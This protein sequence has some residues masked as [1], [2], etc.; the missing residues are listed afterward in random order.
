MAEL[1]GLKERA[2]AS[3][4]FTLPPIDK[5]IEFSV[6]TGERDTIPFGVIAAFEG[7]SFLFGS[8]YPLSKLQKWGDGFWCWDCCLEFKIPFMVHVV[9]YD[10]NVEASKW[11][12]G[13][14]FPDPVERKGDP[15]QT[16]TW[17]LE[18]SDPSD[19]RS[20]SGTYE[21]FTPDAWCEDKRVPLVPQ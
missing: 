3:Y 20:W 14:L 19:N 21:M 8:Q 17:I 13:Y 7:T 15:I 11:V 1:D 10:Q 18:P 6:V 16:G 4:G 2:D 12:E 9:P 5:L